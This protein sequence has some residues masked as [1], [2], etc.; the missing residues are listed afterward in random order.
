MDDEKRVSLI[1]AVVKHA[2]QL[3]DEAWDVSRGGD[4]DPADW[5]TAKAN[6]YVASL[7]RCAEQLYLAGCCLKQLFPTTFE[8]DA[9]SLA[10]LKGLG[11]PVT[12][13]TERADLSRPSVYDRIEE[14]ERLLL[15]HGTEVWRGEKKWLIPDQTRRR[16]RWPS[17]SHASVRST[18]HLLRPSFSAPRFDCGTRSTLQQSPCSCLSPRHANPS[19]AC[20]RGRLFGTQAR[21]RSVQRF[22]PSHWAANYET[23]FK[24][25]IDTVCDPAYSTGGVVETG[26][27]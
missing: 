5:G 21:D 25:I 23:L 3:T 8:L 15:E 19:T 18:P 1:R 7:M 10:F 9:Q 13:I 12:A 6:E 26:G 17:P 24:K 4:T 2:Q 14:Y 16:D 27:R 20:G 11:V 22:N